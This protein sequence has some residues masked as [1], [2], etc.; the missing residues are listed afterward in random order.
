MCNDGNQKS[1]TYK[2]CFLDHSLKKISYF[3][4]IFRAQNLKTFNFLFRILV[5]EIK[6]SK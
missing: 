2:L 4:S 6:K 3:I 1:K 5:A